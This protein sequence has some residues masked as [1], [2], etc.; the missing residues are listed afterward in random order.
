M[1]MQPD[2]TCVPMVHLAGEAAERIGESR[3]LASI[4]EQQTKERNVARWL[5]YSVALLD[6]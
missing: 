1:R 3:V 5:M 2:E 6:T 4:V